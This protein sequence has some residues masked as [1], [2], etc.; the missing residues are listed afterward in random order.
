MYMQSAMLFANKRK[1]THKTVHRVVN[2]LYPQFSNVKVLAGQGQTHGGL[3]TPE[4]LNR[5]FG[6]SFADW[7]N[8]SLLPEFSRLGSVIM[9][10]RDKLNAVMGYIS[11]QSFESIIKDADNK[12]HLTLAEVRLR[13]VDKGSG[14]PRTIDQINQSFLDFKSRNLGPDGIVFNPGDISIILIPL[15]PTLSIRGLMEFHYILPQ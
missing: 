2:P 6:A 1:V 14:V 15:S 8:N 13:I 11:L 7:V 5:R 3:P 12:W 4:E 10:E 9:S